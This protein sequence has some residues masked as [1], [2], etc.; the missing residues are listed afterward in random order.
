MESKIM[1]PKFLRVTVTA[2]NGIDMRQ[3]EA[4]GYR[5]IHT[6]RRPD[7]DLTIDYYFSKETD[8]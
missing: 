2:D 4:L 7:R 8:E 3:Y 6:L 5:L 1:D